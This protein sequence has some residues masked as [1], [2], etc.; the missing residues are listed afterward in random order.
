MHSHF[1]ILAHVSRGGSA[2][3]ASEDATLAVWH[4]AA[5]VVLACCAR[6][7]SSADECRA[8]LSRFESQDEL[9][10]AVEAVTRKRADV[11]LHALVGLPG[12]LC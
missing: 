6:C 3:I 10:A 8:H 5:M 7:A 9:L 11:D 2:A 4:G 1:C 12:P